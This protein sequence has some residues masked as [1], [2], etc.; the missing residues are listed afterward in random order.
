MGLTIDA[1]VYIDAPADVVWRV[2]TDF[3][4]YG[5]WNPFCLEAKTSLIPGEPIDM[6]VQLGPK[7]LRQREY[8]RSHTAGREFSYTMKPVPP[9]AL[10]SLRSHTVTAVTPD[11][12]RYESHFELNGWLNPVVRAVLGKH[13]RNGFEGMTAAVQR[14]AESLHAH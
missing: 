5:D 13:L 2:L 8:V 1:T 4:H 10:H 6:L 14:R 7:R 12:T 11:R 9:N 3:D